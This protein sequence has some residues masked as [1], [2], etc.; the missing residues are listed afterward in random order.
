[1]MKDVISKDLM[2]ISIFLDSWAETSI[3]MITTCMELAVIWDL[4]QATM[5]LE[6]RIATGIEIQEVLFQS[7]N[8]STMRLHTHSTTSKTTKD[9][10]AMS[11]EMVKLIAR[12]LHLT[13]KTG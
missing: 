11:L 12:I 4:Y 9:V 3:L 2:H 13:L 5:L 1:M 7:A 6:V 10:S 8:L